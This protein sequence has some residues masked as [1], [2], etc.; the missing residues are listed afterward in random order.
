M[1][2]GLCS[3]LAVSAVMVLFGVAFEPAGALAAGSTRTTRPTAALVPVVPGDGY[4]QLDGSAAVRALQRSLARVGDAPGLID[5]RYGPVTEQAVERFQSADGLRVDGIAGVHTVA[6][7]STTRGAGLVPAAG[8]FSPGGSAAVR[9]LQRSLVRVGDAPG[10]IDGRYGP[11]TERAVRRFQARAGLRVTG[12][13]GLGTIADLRSQTVSRVRPEPV[14]PRASGRPRVSQPKSQSRP[15]ASGRAPRRAHSGGSSVNGWLVGL[16]VIV[17]G[18]VLIAAW[19]WRGLRAARRSTPLV[20]SSAAPAVELEQHSNGAVPAVVGD[21]DGAPAGDRHAD[22]REDAQGALN[23]GLLLESR[24][25]LAGAEAAFASADER[26]DAK[27]AFNLGV[28]LA[29]RGDLAG[30][31]AAYR[32]ADQRGLPAGAWGLGVLLSDRGDLA[33]AETAY[34]RADQRGDAKG[35]FNL[36]VLLGERGDAGAEA[37]YRRADQRG[38]AK[39]AFNLGV[40]LAERED[41]A[42]AEAAYRRADQRGLPAASTGLGVLLTQRGDL[43]GAE[44]AYRRADQRGD[45][46][47][48]FNLGVLLGERGDAGAEAAYRRADQRGDAKGAFNLGVLLRQ[49]GDLAG[50]QAALTRAQQRGDE[51]DAAIA[52][53]ALL[54]LHARA[55]TDNGGQIHNGRQIHNGGQT[56][57]EAQTHS[58]A[59]R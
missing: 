31:E 47:G 44:T 45:A 9:S 43:A 53:D 32:R 55:H 59:S 35:A 34:R 19:Y 39:G 26:G 54:D 16:G 38:D 58:G 3:L 42:G 25:D 24:N 23:L 7:L 5:G 17:L 30:A 48:A 28:L 33:G 46:K 57:N 1:R 10:P 12:I 22:Q 18:L 14:V 29:E 52:R 21:L 49:R 41:L 56:H 50:A 8:D 20:P 6:A 51:D 40:L 15:L 13:A 27:G 36:G 37:A 4:F 11:L 2:R